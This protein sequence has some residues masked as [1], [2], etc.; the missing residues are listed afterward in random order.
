LTC[1]LSATSSPPEFDLEICKY[2]TPNMIR[3]YTENND[4]VNNMP[5]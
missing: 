4:I 2:N 3:P 1:I 5:E